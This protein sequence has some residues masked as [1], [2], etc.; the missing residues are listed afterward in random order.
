M[1]KSRWAPFRS[2]RG[3]SQ[4]LPHVIVPYGN[5]KSDILR[6]KLLGSL[7]DGS[8]HKIST[9]ALSSFF[10]RVVGITEYFPRPVGRAIAV[11]RCVHLLGGPRKLGS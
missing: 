5:S 2:L 3:M 4:F 7:L 1:H 8:V 11:S 6:D 10:R 9:E